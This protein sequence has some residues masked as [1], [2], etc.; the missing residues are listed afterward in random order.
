MSYVGNERNY[1]IFV[2]SQL[3]HRLD[4]RARSRLHQYLA[5]QH[6][7]AWKNVVRL[8]VGCLGSG[9]IQKS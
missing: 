7:M 8:P 3:L 4:S 1:C 6:F 9:G 2:G 5:L